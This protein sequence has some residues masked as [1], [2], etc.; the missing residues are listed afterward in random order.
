VC[1]H[2]RTRA[3]CTAADKPGAVLLTSASSGGQQS[4]QEGWSVAAAF[5][6]A[7]AVSTTL[8][9]TGSEQRVAFIAVAPESGG[10]TKGP[11]WA[12]G[13]ET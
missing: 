1:T 9:V 12:I 7:S 2:T 11:E 3:S 13:V 8:D 5:P 10:Q 6:D 4:S